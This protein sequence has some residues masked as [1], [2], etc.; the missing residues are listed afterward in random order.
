MSLLLLPKYGCPIEWKH[1]EVVPAEKRNDSSYY[2]LLYILLSLRAK[3]Y[4][5]NPYKL[6]QGKE[7]GRNKSKEKQFKNFEW[8]T[9]ASPGDKQKTTLSRYENYNKNPNLNPN[10]NP[11]QREGDMETLAVIISLD[12]K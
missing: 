2:I 8:D 5:Q 6:A 9:E 1:V 12:I 10:P 11:K 3:C 7:D 4:N